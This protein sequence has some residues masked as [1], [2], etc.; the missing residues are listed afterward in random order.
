[1]R[2]I[3]YGVNCVFYFQ[4]EHEHP[5]NFRMSK[6]CYL[7][8]KVHNFTTFWFGMM[9]EISV[10]WNFCCDPGWSV[11]ILKI[12][13][14]ITMPLRQNSICQEESKDE[15]AYGEKPSVFPTLT[16]SQSK[17]KNCKFE[18]YIIWRFQNANFNQCDTLDLHKNLNV[19]FI[20]LS[21]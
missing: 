10:I 19:L 3:F 20:I 12:P 5:F 18:H 16:F 21:W 15:V 17:M 7:F 13:M 14:P 9:W 8:F 11:I 2:F 1:M 6:V 4:R